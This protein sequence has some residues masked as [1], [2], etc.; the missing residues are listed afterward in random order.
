MSE[1]ES[2]SDSTPSLPFAVIDDIAAQVH[3][4]EVR[5]KQR[6]HVRSE[7]DED[8]E[9]TIQ[10]FQK[11]SDRAKDRR[12]ESVRAVLSAAELAGYE[13]AKKGGQ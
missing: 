7:W 11:L 12:R 13:I 9:E 10:P 5:G 1:I 6:G 2:S 3:D 8:G 4:E